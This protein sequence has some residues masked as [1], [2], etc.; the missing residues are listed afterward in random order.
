MRA[1]AA[2]LRSVTG[3]AVVLERADWLGQTIRLSGGS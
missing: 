2:V 1:Q 3:Q